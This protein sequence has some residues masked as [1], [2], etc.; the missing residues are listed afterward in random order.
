MLLKRREFVTVAALGGLATVFGARQAD[1]QVLEAIALFLLTDVVEP[2]VKSAI[3][4]YFSD[5]GTALGRS[6]YAAT[7][8]SPGALRGPGR[9]VITATV[10][11]QSS[12][13]VTIHAT[14]P[15]GNGQRAITHDGT[16]PDYQHAAT[17]EHARQI[18]VKAHNWMRT[19]NR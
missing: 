2:Y 8:G 7:S 11:K 12:G 3:H 18:V 17:R 1:A 5:A 4:S 13:G 16:S 6:I 19:H 15:D 9:A 10:Q 14:M